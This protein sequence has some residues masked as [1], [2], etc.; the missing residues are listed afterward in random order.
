MLTPR[1]RQQ[2]EKRLDR[3]VDQIGK[4]RSIARSRFYPE[5]YRAEARRIER[6]VFMPL[7][8]VLDKDD[9]E[10]TAN[11]PLEHERQVQLGNRL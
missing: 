2:A 8:E 9:Q 6:E 3:A 7:C 10:R 11:E 1:Q 5:N 4:C